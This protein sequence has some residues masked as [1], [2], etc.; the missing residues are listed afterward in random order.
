MTLH[1]FALGQ[2]VRI[3]NKTKIFNNYGVP[4]RVMGK[5]GKIDALP[6]NKKTSTSFNI[7]AVT[8]SRDTWWCPEQMIE[9]VE[10]KEDHQ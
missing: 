9:A 4:D 7:Y 3:V 2:K 6:L 5:V 10:D 1:T 8:V